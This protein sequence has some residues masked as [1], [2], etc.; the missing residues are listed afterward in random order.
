MLVIAARHVAASLKLG[1]HYHEF[2]NRSHF[3]TPFAELITVLGAQL[4]H[5]DEG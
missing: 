2:T 1:D 4:G 3:F 5:G